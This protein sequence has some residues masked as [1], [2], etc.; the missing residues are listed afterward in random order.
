[1]YALFELTGTIAGL[2]VSIPESVDLLAF[3]VGLV[4]VAMTGRWLIGRIEDGNQSEV[5]PRA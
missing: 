2:F 5:A 3:G 1:M 4:S